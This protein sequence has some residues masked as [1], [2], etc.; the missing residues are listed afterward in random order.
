MVKKTNNKETK[1]DK[2]WYF[3]D[4]ARWTRAYF[5][6]AQSSGISS[7]L[8][9]QFSVIDRLAISYR[10]INHWYEQGLLDDNR[11]G[12]EWRRVT[13]M[14]FL[15]LN[16]IAE[17]REWGLPI[18]T[19]KLVKQSLSVNS[20]AT[21]LKMPLLEY[22]VFLC[23]IEKIPVTLLVF[24]DGSCAPI[25]YHNYKYN[26]SVGL[27]NHLN[28]NINRIVQ[29][30]FPNSDLTPVYPNEI[31]LSQEQ[32]ALLEFANSG[33]FESIHV[34]YKNGKMDLI[35]GMEKIETSKKI[36]EIIREHKYQKIEFNI[37]DGKVVYAKRKIRKKVSD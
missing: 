10:K 18:D 7:L 33:Q 1:A 34:T 22:C 15:W 4:F 32:Y 3:E 2:V 28:I 37:S 24:Q 12:N 16:I 26:L 19:I 17:L 21:G 30:V 13:I 6:N 35:E 29:T 27:E 36:T 25:T 31:K 5:K 11:Q 14:E 9:N 20:E 23:A 8:N